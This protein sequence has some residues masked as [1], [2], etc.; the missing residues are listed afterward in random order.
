MNTKFIEEFCA[1]TGMK[2]V[3]RGEIGFGRE[4]VGI[5]NPETDC[6]L[7]YATYDKGYN[8]KLVHDVAQNTAPKN[9]YHKGPYL[10]VLFDGT[11]EGRADAINQLNSWIEKIAAAAYDLTEYEETDSVASLLNGGPVTQ[12]CLTGGVSFGKFIEIF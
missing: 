12:I 11:E 5:M 2:F 10:A 8:E 6:Y 3:D 1:D 9:A 7:A 4:C